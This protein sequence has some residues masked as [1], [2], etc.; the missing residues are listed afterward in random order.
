MC[1][2][3]RINTSNK[4]WISACRPN[5]TIVNGKS[6]FC[7][8]HFDDSQFVICRDNSK[9]MLLK[10]AYPTINVGMWPTISDNG[11]EETCDRSV[12]DVAEVLTLF[13]L[14]VIKIWFLIMLL[15]Y[16]V[17]ILNRNTK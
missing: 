12:V 5:A 3:Y 15:S 17:S 6:F 13:M 8:A 1:P 7:S 14:F 10:D 16:T 9:K 11:Q 4:K 2:R